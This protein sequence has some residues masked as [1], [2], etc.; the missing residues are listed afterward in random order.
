VR[1]NLPIILVLIAFAAAAY[2]YYELSIRSVV[3][4]VPFV[5]TPPEV[6]DAMLELAEVKKDDVVYDLGCGDGRILIAAAKKYGCR[7]VGYDLQPE[8]VSQ[9]RDNAQAAG[10]ADLVTIHRQDI[11]EVDLKDA[12]VVALF[13]SVP[14]NERLIPQIDAMPPGRRIVSYHFH[15]PGIKPH[16]STEV[17][18]G[19]SKYRVW[20]WVTPLERE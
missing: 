19:I 3:P 20:L 7:A 17:Q 11:F 13:L 6:V 9:A 12:T 14:V 18:S 10:V 8:L 4:D 5:V 16:K 2:A 15:M 1:R